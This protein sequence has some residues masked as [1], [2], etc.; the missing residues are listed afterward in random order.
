MHNKKFSL[1]VSD[2][3]CVALA[4][5]SQSS[6]GPPQILKGVK[7]CGCLFEHSSSHECAK[8]DSQAGVRDLCRELSRAVAATQGHCA[9]QETLGHVE[10]HFRLSL[11][12]MGSCRCLVGLPKDP[13]GAPECTA[14]QGCTWPPMAA[15]LRVGCPLRSSGSP[16]GGTPGPPSVRLVGQERALERGQLGESYSLRTVSSWHLQTPRPFD[17]TIR[18]AELPSTWTP[19]P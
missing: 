3:K 2:M 10:R 17:P 13:G 14:P 6:M 4:H 5:L 9:L 18:S 1:L 8:H 11:L 16:V 7:R 12:G 15:V 19:G